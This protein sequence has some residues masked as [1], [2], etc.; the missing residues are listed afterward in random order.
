MT[1]AAASLPPAPRPSTEVAL[2]HEAREP[3]SAAAV[4][5]VLGATV[6][7]VLSAAMANVALPALAHAFRVSPAAAVRVVGAY[8]LGLVMALLPAAALAESVGPRRVFTAGIVGFTCASAAC[9][10]APS[11]EALIVARFLQGVGGAAAMALGVALLRFAVPPARMTS[12][13]AWNALAV[14]GSTAAAPSLGAVLLASARWP[15]LFAV[16]LPLGLAVLL[17]TRALPDVPGTGRPVDRMSMA[18]SAGAFGALFVGVERL[19]LEPVFGGLAIALAGLLARLVLRRESP[20]ETPAI[21]LDLLRSR[22]TRLAALASMVCF[23][24]QGAALVALP[25]LLQRS[26]D[27]EALSIGLLITPWPL[28]VALTAPVAGRLAD[29]IASGWLCASGASVLAVGLGALA[30]FPTHLDPR[31]LTPFVAL[32]GV[33]FGLFQVPNNR[34]LLLDAPRARSAAAGALQAT[35]RLS[36]Q[37]AGSVLM[38]LTFLLA[39]L[40]AAP[41]IGLAAG[42][43]A[44][45]AAGA[46]S[47]LRAESSARSHASPSR[48]TPE[49]R[50]A[51]GFRSRG[52]ARHVG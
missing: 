25:F 52:S 47:L 51:R 44:A 21:P 34:T 10:V 39:P 3:A 22:T 50:S 18:W 16:N 29:R 32:A 6:L 40:D 14:A 5:S 19:P 42:A 13:I 31:W 8:Q 36:G 37:T 49:S 46:I 23:A 7:V 2:E 15:W 38:T 27:Q 33:G 41:R 4:A 43:V 35:A 1:T 9:V 26:F 17:A 45:L 20:K 28:G 12:V 48:E 11:L 30:L 24:G